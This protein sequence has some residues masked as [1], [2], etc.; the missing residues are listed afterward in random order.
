MQ[1]LWNACMQALQQKI[2][3]ELFNTWT[4]PL[5]FHAFTQGVLYIGIPSRVFAEEMVKA[6]HV[7]FEQAIYETFGRGTRV[8]WKLEVDED[9]NANAGKASVQRPNTRNTPDA[10]N[11]AQPT[12]PKGEAMQSFLNEEYTFERFCKGESN[13]QALNIARSIAARLNDQTFNPFFLYGPSGVGK[14]HLVTAIGL[15]V[16]QHHPEKRVLFVSAAT[17]RTQYT[18]AVRT[19]KVND[20]VHFYQT[21]DV[22]IIDDFQEIKT[23]KTQHVFFHIFNHLQSLKRKIIITCDRPPSQFEG[24][25]ERLLTRLKWGITIDI[26][27]PDLQL[28]RDIL[29]DK[30]RR[31]NITSFPEEVVQ[32]IAEN[33][34]DSVREL[35]GMVNSMLAFSMGNSGACSIDIDLAKRII[36]RLVNQARKELNMETIMNFICERKDMKLTDLRS[37]TRKAPVVAARHLVCYLT[38]KY[39]ETPLAQIGRAL[40]GR[41]HSTIV[42][43]CAKME[44]QMAMNKVFRAE[45]EALETE[46]SQL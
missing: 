2:S 44:K 46:L 13:Q 34:S 20:F 6:L 38:H 32:Y 27:R 7:P 22:L 28:R 24:I 40:G 1:D 23:E 16:K 10:P 31:E 33:V 8:Q 35:Q 41:D 14:T 5:K 18:D 36:P 4:R 21:I 39:T 26:Q 9:P 19:N 29:H 25:E 30:L 3:P 45:I 43:S 11:A 15:E 12:S 42:H 17:F 37:K